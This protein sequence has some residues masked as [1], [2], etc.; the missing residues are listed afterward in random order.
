MIMLNKQK[1][2]L[3]LAACVVAVLAI[4]YLVLS[5]TV[6]KA[7]PV[8]NETVDLHLFPAIESK[9]VSLIK[10]KNPSGSYVC[11]RGSDGEL[12]FQGAE[13]QIYDTLLTSTLLAYVSSPQ[14]TMEVTDYN[15]EDLSVYG[16]ASGQ[17]QVVFTVEGPVG[18]GISYTVRVGSLLVNGAGYYTM[19][20]GVDRLFV[21]S[22]FYETA[23]FADLKD[24]FA[25]RVAVPLV[26]DEQT[27]AYV[28]KD[29]KLYN[30]EELVLTIQPS[31]E[32]GEDSL[33]TDTLYAYQ[34]THPRLEWVDNGTFNTVLEG[35]KD[36]VGTRVVE[37]D[38]EKMVSA[39][40]KIRGGEEVAPDS[41]L[42]KL[43]YE[44][45][46]LFQK[47][48]LMDEAF[49]FSHVLEYTNGGFT[50]YVIFSDVN[51]DG[52]FYAY[53]SDFDLIAEFDGEE[54]AFLF[55]D[56][57]KYPVKALFNHSVYDL[58]KFEINSPAVNA[59]FQL[60]MNSDKSQL[61]T[62][63]D[64]LSGLEVKT[65][66]FKQMYRGFLYFANYGQAEQGDATEPSLTVKVTVSDGSEYEFVFYDISDLKCYYT[67]NGEGGY[68]VTRDNVRALIDYAQKVLKG[69]NFTA[70]MK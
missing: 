52:V 68:Y 11:Y 34:M 30:H 16:L 37:F 53:S 58:S 32:D 61:L 10:V 13:R 28:V 12:Y 41:E 21:L 6:L 22:T 62:A 33:V 48:G 31:A 64:T 60:T 70:S 43:A 59:S 9:D 51:E 35:L 4:G 40:Q 63:K 46:V 24:F 25:P 42:G 29:F 56:V 47:Y 7:P 49:L 23:L 18:S 57:E 3:I 54:Y 20:D 50:S 5:L 44:A 27:N 69:E 66:L 67:V 36:F 38:L 15:K 17:E 45:L 1:K 65:D 55:W 2:W 39:L 8:T 19:V 14:A 26:A